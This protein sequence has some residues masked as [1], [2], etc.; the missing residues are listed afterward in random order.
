MGAPE[1]PD[2]APEPVVVDEQALRRAEAYVEE[3]EGAANRL[4][5]ALGAVVA[6]LAIAMSLFHLYAAYSIIPTHALRAVHVAFVLVLS[7]LVSPWPGASGTVSC[8]G[9]GSPRRRRWSWSRT[10]S[11]GAT[12]SPTGTPRRTPGTSSSA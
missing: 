7:F 6:A 2:P 12:T 11:T 3:E 4:K 10:C 5:G 8:G 1:R 9:T